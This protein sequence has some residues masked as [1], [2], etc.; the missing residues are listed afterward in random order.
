ME[1]ILFTVAFVIESIHVD[2]VC[3]WA[4]SILREGNVLNLWEVVNV[5]RMPEAFLLQILI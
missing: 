5:G 3:A 1:A 2:R 4:A